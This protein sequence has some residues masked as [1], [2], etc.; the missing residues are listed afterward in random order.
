MS[1]A[2]TPPNRHAAQPWITVTLAVIGG[3][4][5]AGSGATA[6]FAAAGDLGRTSTVQRVGV[7]GVESLDLNA[8]AST[9]RVE[10]ADVSEAEL[11]VDGGGAWR[12]DRNDDELVVRSPDTWFGWWFGRWFGDDSTVVLT[13]PNHLQGIDASFVLS[14]GGLD[15]SGTFDD[16]SV[17]L[18]AGDLNVD[19]TATTLDADVS[20]GSADLLLDGVDEADLSMSAGTLNVELTGT[21]PSSVTVD[22]NAGTTE[23]TL[24]DGGYRVTQNVS[25]GTLDNRLE[26]S[27]S[28]RNSVDVSL[29]AGTVTLRPGR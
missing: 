5:L 18:A 12:I 22:V 20:A 28:S 25:A 27:S 9:V 29:S 2:P 24:P 21:A 11:S 23:I 17:E 19:G 7:D 14:A 1:I 26:Y 15:V 3:L 16:L 8:S 10:F 13:L 4:A 6:A